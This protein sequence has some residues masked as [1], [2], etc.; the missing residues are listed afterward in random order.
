MNRHDHMRSIE[1]TDPNP[2]RSS[3]R[4]ADGRRTMPPTELPYGWNERSNQLPAGDAVA[5]NFVARGAYAVGDARTDASNWLSSE[6]VQEH[7][8]AR[9]EAEKRE[10][11]GN[12]DGGEG[13]AGNT[14]A[15]LPSGWEERQRAR[16]AEAER[17]AAAPNASASAR[18]TTFGAPTRVS[19]EL[20]LVRCATAQLESI[21]S[22]L[23]NTHVVLPDEDR[24]AFSAAV[25]R[26]S[27]AVLRARR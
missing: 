15:R 23:T 25:K 16:A 6:Q 12:P 26:S 19:A 20:A 1:F 24:A 13:D 11:G 5:A 8:F 9:I 18:P 7:W 27:D 4:S 3:Q 14:A 21:A 22:V 17:F 10:R 2:L